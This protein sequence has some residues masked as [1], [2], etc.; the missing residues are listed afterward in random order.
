VSKLLKG[1]EFD[2]VDNL[3]ALG[4]SAVP[5]LLEIAQANPD[6]LTRARINAALGLLGDRRAIPVLTAELTSAGAMQRLTAVRALAQVG[7]AEAIA[8][9]IGLLGDPDPSMSKI[10]IESLATIGDASAMAALQKIR[11]ETPHEF[12]RTLAE[13]ATEEIKKR[14]T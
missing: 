9:L 13:A 7:G 12:L 14:I 3:V 8:P 10:A 6:P 11:T 1:E 5:V 4:P 2:G